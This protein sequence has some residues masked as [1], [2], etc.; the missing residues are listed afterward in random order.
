LNV[1]ASG[2]TSDTVLITPSIGEVEDQDE[3]DTGV[4]NEE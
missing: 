4:A 2:A 1:I 3:N